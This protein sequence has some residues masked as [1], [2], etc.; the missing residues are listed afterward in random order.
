M[1][2]NKCQLNDA[3]IHITDTGEDYCLDCHN[4][5][6]A[7]M[8]GVK[9]MQGFSKV[10]S[11]YNSDK[12]M[13]TFNISNTIMPGH[14]IWQA[15]EQGGGY[16]YEVFTDPESDQALAIRKLHQKILNGIGYKTLELCDSKYYM[17]NA[18]NYNKK[19]YS[20]N[21]VGTFRIEY[22]E[23]E[24]IRLVIDGKYI[25]ANDFC[26][27]LSSF[28]GFNMDYQIRDLSDEIL[29]KNMVL[30]PVCIDPEVIYKHFEKTL[31]WFLNKNFLS[32][33]RSSDC[34]EALFERIDELELLF[35]YGEREKAVE[36]G[37]RMKKRLLS[38]DNDTDDFPI[39]LLELIDK[40]VEIED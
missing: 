34:T 27:A 17:S 37:N 21:T 32:Y 20:L 8:L 18:I 13:L 25:S 19:Q 2:C 31:G 9:K 28:E 5:I 29:G 14:S 10:V 33:K 16:L 35:N 36:L 26:K 30:R 6:M 23:R 39:Y 11:F 1:K 7:E 38:I 40:A 24:K 15:E 3:I 22:N 4:D 12:E